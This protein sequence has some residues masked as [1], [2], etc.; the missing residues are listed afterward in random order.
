MAFNVARGLIAGSQIN[1]ADREWA[2]LMRQEARARMAYLLPPDTILCLPTTPFPAPTRGLPLP[3]LGPLRSRISCL[4]SH[5][6]L[7]GVPQVSIPGAEV[8]G[9]PVGLSIVGGR[10]SDAMLVAVARAMAP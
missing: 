3:V 1:E 9:L 8:N 5:G 2:E 7:T 6:G 10:G 4:C